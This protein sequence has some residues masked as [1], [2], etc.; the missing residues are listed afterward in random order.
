MKPT[1]KLNPIAA[2]KL[3]PQEE[4]AY[5][6]EYAQRAMDRMVTD[7]TAEIEKLKSQLTSPFH[8]LDRFGWL[9]SYAEGIAEAALAE[10][11][12][13][14]A[15]ELVAKEQ[16]FEVALEA[17]IKREREALLNNHYRASSTSGYN[18]ATEDA[19][20]EAASRFIRRWESQ[21]AKIKELRAA[22][23]AAAVNL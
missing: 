7:A 5:H 20:R 3:T 2:P 14:I 9:S 18:N 11:V 12:L 6:V 23:A 16:P 10:T 15:K 21:V 1:K 4:L 19:R 22:A 8:A 13:E 17:V